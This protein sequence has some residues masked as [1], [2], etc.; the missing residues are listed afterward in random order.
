M[1]SPFGK[2]ANEFR[3]IHLFKKSV[4]SPTAPYLSG[5]HNFQAISKPIDR[6]VLN[7]EGSVRTTSLESL[8]SGRHTTS[9]ES[10]VRLV[11]SSVSPRIMEQ[12]NSQKCLIPKPSSKTSSAVGSF[13]N[14]PDMSSVKTHSRV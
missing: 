8:R 12:V 1:I 7:Y 2:K 3:D 11:K 10:K 13:V 9:E 5:E 14:S 6:V 4:T